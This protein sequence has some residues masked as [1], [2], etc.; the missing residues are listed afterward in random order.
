MLGNYNLNKIYN[1]D[2]YLALSKIQD[3]SIDLIY[4]DIPYKIV[5]GG[6][7]AGFLKSKTRN[8][9]YKKTIGEFADG[10]DF[11]ILDEFIRILKKINIYIW[12]S[13][14]Q[15]VD[16][17]NY[18]VKKKKCNY[19]ILVWCKSNSTPFCNNTFLP[20]IEYCL[21]FR[22]AGVKLNDGYDLKS[23]WYISKTNTTDKSKYGHPTIKPL[24]LVKNHIK[25][26]TKEKDV[27]LDPFLGSGTTA[28][29]CKNTNRNYIGFEINKEYYNIAKNRLEG[30]EKSGQT[31]LFAD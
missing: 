29:A 14:E 12:C 17:L 2:C 25:H 21:Y 23:K 7:G 18:F 5:N 4:T 11:K 31:K 16:I 19:E 13:K 9:F 27:V 28:V 6:S 10:I 1:E 24:N 8:E 30:I 26:T 22:E 3:N 20:N 15:I